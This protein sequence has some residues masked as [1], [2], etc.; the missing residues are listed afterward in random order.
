MGP[1]AS[2]GWTTRHAGTSG[3]CQACARTGG[4]GFSLLGRM[5]PRIYLRAGKAAGLLTS[6]ASTSLTFASAKED[7]TAR[8]HHVTEIGLIA[9][10]SSHLKDNRHP[11][12]MFAHALSHYRLQCM[13]CWPATDTCILLPVLP[14]APFLRAPSQVVDVDRQ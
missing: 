3:R 1:N 2:G 9:L 5:R 14:A 10:H 8:Q 6:W 4:L 12:D 7:P 13:P 11:M